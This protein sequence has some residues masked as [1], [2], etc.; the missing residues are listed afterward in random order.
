MYIANIADMIAKT[1]QQKEE[2]DFIAANVNIKLHNPRNK[3]IE[4]SKILKNVFIFLS[5]SV[6]IP[7]KSIT[8]WDS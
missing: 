8:F 3:I 4:T 5:F 7:Y 6:L 2:G 1:I